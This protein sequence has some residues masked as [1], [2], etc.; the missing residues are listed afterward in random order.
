MRT[1][2]LYSSRGLLLTRTAFLEPRRRAA[3]SD[4]I[5]DCNKLCSL[6]GFE[7]QTVS[8]QQTEQEKGAIRDH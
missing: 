3:A 5:Q 4:F 2:Q 7:V 8:Q 1:V 6:S